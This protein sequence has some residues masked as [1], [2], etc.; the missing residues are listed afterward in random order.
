MQTREVVLL[1]NDIPDHAVT[2]GRA[3]S[4]N[5]YHVHLARTGKDA[6]DLIRHTTPECAVIDL[7]LPDMSGWDL[8]RE[9]KKRESGRGLPIVVLTPDLSK[10]CATDS[11]RV[12][13]D[14]WLAHPTVA[15]DLVQ[16]VKRV[17]DLETASPSSP[18][19]ALLHVIECGAC[20]SDHVRPTLRVGDVQYYCCKSCGFCWRAE[21]LRAKPMH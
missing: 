1:V 20:A 7:R 10:M 5:G 4:Q 6:L 17:L 13:C 11:A 12:G 14:A 21:R 8:C 18:E 15:Q 3:L 16:T 2:Y 19:D 9:L